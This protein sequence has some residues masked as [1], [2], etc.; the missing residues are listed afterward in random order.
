MEG[1]LEQ[2]DRLIEHDAFKGCIK[3]VK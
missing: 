3:I 1:A 2:A